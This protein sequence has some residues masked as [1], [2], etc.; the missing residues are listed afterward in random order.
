MSIEDFLIPAAFWMKNYLDGL[1]NSNTRFAVWD[2]NDYLSQLYIYIFCFFTKMERKFQIALADNGRGGL[3]KTPEAKSEK[4]W[5]DSKDAVLSSDKGFPQ[6]QYFTFSNF[7]GWSHL[8]WLLPPIHWTLGCSNEQSPWKCSSWVQ[9]KC[10]KGQNAIPP[11]AAQNAQVSDRLP[12]TAGSCLA[13]KTA[14]NI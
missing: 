3:P 5:R 9:F 14:E 2:T 6:P 10:R 12:K 7:A 1:R 4:S 11:L 8:W 13:R